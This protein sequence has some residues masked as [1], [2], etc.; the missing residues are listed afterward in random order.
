MART[1]PTVVVTRKLPDVVETRMME[2]FNVHLNEDD[3]PFTANELADALKKSD[4][5]LTTL[6]DP[7]SADVIAKA[8]KDL[9]LIANFGNGV[10]HIDVPA[11]QKRGITVTNT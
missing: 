8:G 9:K 4:V 7:I 5:V 1:K 6:T 10:D 2:L 3:H 11:A